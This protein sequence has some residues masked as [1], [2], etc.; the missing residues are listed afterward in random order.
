M[1]DELWILTKIVDDSHPCWDTRQTVIGTPESIK[2]SFDLSKGVPH[3]WR[4]LRG[5]K[6]RRYL[7]RAMK[8]ELLYQRE[9]QIR[10]VAGGDN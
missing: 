4:L 9:Q 10:R 7:H 6:A 1:A 8:Q 2:R 3:G 5:K